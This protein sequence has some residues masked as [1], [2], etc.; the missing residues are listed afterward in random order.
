MQVFAL[1]YNKTYLF[2]RS[3]VSQLD[4]LNKTQACEMNIS[5]VSRCPLANSYT[6]R[7][8]FYNVKIIVGVTV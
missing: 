2:T 4:N 8:D 6:Y 5:P 7:N 3:Y 1:R